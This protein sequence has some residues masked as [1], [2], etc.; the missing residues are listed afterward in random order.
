MSRLEIKPRSSEVFKSCSNLYRLSFAVRSILKLL[1][2]VRKLIREDSDAWS[3][4]GRKLAE[5]PF[6]VLKFA[7]DNYNIPIKF[8]MTLP[9]QRDRPVAVVGTCVATKR[10][11]RLP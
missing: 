2:I 1:L 8:R 5:R 9:S 10:R 7:L 4:K 6:L 3:A 11:R